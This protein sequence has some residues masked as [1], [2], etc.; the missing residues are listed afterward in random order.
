MSNLMIKLNGKM[1]LEGEKFEK[2]RDALH[3]LLTTQNIAAKTV[4]T[5]LVAVGGAGYAD[6]LA[7][8][9]KP[10]DVVEIFDG[11]VIAAKY[12]RKNLVN[13]IRVALDS[14]SW[15]GEIFTAK[16]EKKSTVTQEIAGF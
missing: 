6:T 13:R 16:S 4:Q 11:E 8:L 7:K 12:T 14:A 15:T 3:G 10:D 9:G 2:T 1:I 5:A